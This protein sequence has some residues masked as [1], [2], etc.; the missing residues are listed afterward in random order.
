MLIK[1]TTALLGVLTLGLACLSLTACNDHVKEVEDNVQT[2]LDEAEVYTEQAKIPMRPENLDTVTMKEDIWLGQD[3]FKITGGEPFPLSLETPDAL[4]ISYA[5][6]ITLVDLVNDLREMTGLRF[7]L[8]ELRANNELPDEAFELNYT[9]SLS[10]LLDY[11]SHKYSIWWRNRKGTVSFYKMET[12]VFTIYALPTESSMSASL[13]GT[14]ISSGSNSSSSA[15]GTTSLQMSSSVTLSF[16]QKIEEGIRQVMGS[17]GDML[18]DSTSGSVTVTAPPYIIQKI[19]RY[20]Q[21]LNE[22]M[23]RQVAISVKVFQVSLENSDQYGL[24]LNVLYN[25]SKHFGAAVANTFSTS[26]TSGGQMT[27]TLLDGAFKDSSSIIKALST[28]GKTSLVTSTSVTTLNNKVAPVQVTTQENYVSKTTIE[29]DNS[30]SSYNSTSVEMETET[31]NYGFTMEILPRILDNGRLMMLF[32]MTL[33]DLI[34]LTKF[35]SDGSTDD[36]TGNSDS[37]SSSS[38]G[39]S[40][41][42][43]SSSGSSGSSGS[44][45]SGSGSSSGSS[46]ENNSNN[47]DKTTVQLPKMQ[48]RGFVQEIAMR[49]GSTLVLTGFEQVQNKATGSGVGQP[50][51]SILGGE[52]TAQQIRNVMVIL[53]TPEILESPLS[54]ET[55]ME[56]F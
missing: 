52:A 48:T 29:K 50:R 25:K 5:E 3:S 18:I 56:R 24:D 20:V 39:S 51:I 41:S 36:G 4:T 37:S 49:S 9:G 13:S 44:G 33:T 6:P 14:P 15:G 7:S 8:D 47:T 1:K 54:P 34:S 12:R 10:G 45:S 23:S 35:S 26:M 22:K 30:D 38:S 28:Q 19:A 17:Q 11:I 42:S 21:A 40:G 55:R 46:T 2:V 53:I 16:W 32:S 43:G 27:L 31:L